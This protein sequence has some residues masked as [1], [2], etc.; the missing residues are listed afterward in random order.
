[1]IHF[2]PTRNSL[3]FI[4]LV[5]AITVVI[6][7]AILLGGFGVGDIFNQP[8]DL[9]TGVVHGFFGDQR[10]PHRWQRPS[11]LDS[12]VT[13]G[14]GFCASSPGF[15]FVVITAFFIGAIAW[16]TTPHPAPH[17]CGLGC[18]LKAPQGPFE[19]VYRNFLLLMQQLHD[20]EHAEQWPVERITLD[21]IL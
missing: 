9:G 21:V 4:R 19:Y 2:L 5:L 15:G 20:L 13:S 18:Y 14:N 11:K 1:M 10:L 16:M 17:A 3:N 6:S 7:H 12:V 8:T